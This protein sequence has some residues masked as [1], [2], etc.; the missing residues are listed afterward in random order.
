[1]EKLWL[2]F[3][4][5]ESNYG[6]HAVRNSYFAS[7]PQSITDQSLQ[8]LYPGFLKPE[9]FISNIEILITYHLL[10]HLRDILVDIS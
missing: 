4:L 7:S 8:S 5:A 1:M 9:P 6:G 2:S 3:P 10:T